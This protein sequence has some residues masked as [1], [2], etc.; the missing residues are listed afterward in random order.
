[1]TA[2]HKQYVGQPVI[3]QRSQ[4]GTRTRQVALRVAVHCN[5]ELGEWMRGRMNPEDVERM[6]KIDDI[7]KGRINWVLYDPTAAYVDDSEVPDWRGFREELAS[8]PLPFLRVQ[9]DEPRP[10][11]SVLRETLKRIEESEEPPF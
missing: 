10:D 1:V 2:W 6:L 4:D 7:L 5:C 11:P 9:G 3:I 8:R